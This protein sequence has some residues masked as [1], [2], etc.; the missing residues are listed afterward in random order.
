LTRFYPTT[1]AKRA[2]ATQQ[3]PLS[4]HF[5]VSASADDDEDAVSMATI[6]VSVQRDAIHGRRFAV[7]L[8][9]SV[10][11]EAVPID[12]VAVQVTLTVSQ[13]VEHQRRLH[14]RRMVGAR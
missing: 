14:G 5:S 9:V 3:T 7:H 11:A 10:F 12:W 1:C 8:V 2:S 13:P 4:A 6:N